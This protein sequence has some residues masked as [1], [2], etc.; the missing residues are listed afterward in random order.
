M[1]RLEQAK[2]QYAYLANDSIH[3]DQSLLSSAIQL[4]GEEGNGKFEAAF[5]GAWI[6]DAHGNIVDEAFTERK[7]IMHTD[8]NA[9]FDSIGGPLNFLSFFGLAQG[10]PA[11]V[12]E[13]GRGQGRAHS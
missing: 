5:S 1:T 11:R 6:C 4:L 3:I 13:K 8:H 12:V 7:S 2:G 9:F 10:G